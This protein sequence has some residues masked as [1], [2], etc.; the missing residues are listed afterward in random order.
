VERAWEVLRAAGVPDGAI[1]PSPRSLPEAPALR[2]ALQE[3][4]AEEPLTVSRSLEAL[5][6]W[7]AAFRQHWPSRFGAVLGPEGIAAHARL[8]RLD[9]DRNRYL[10]LRRIALENLGGKAGGEAPS[11]VTDV[12]RGGR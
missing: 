4:L 1:R 8:D 12:P 10:K 5:N 7:L 3:V 11:E 6:A 9:F 2:A